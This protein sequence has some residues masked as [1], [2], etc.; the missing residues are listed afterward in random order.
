M[1]LDFTFWLV[2]C[3]RENV[4]FSSICSNVLEGIE[5]FYL[6]WWIKEIQLETPFKGNN[7]KAL[8]ITSNCENMVLY[9]SVKVQKII[10]FAIPFW[11]TFLVY[12]CLISLLYLDLYVLGDD[13]LIR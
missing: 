2:L 6:L 13:P 3:S 8:K 12:L 4:S 5:R 11:F 9:F 10:A 1:T 7:V